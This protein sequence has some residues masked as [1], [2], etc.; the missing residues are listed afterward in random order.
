VVAPEPA[1]AGWL[2]DKSGDAFVPI[3]FAIG[4]FMLTIA[5]NIAFRFAQRSEPSVQRLP[6]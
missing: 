1:I 4:L 2:Y 5:G 6:S 3:L